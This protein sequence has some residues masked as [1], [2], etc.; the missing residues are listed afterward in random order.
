VTISV[1]RHMTSQF[2]SSPESLRAK[3]DEIDAK[4]KQ[5]QKD[6]ILALHRKKKGAKKKKKKYHI[7]NKVPSPVAEKKAGAETFYC[8]RCGWVCR[9]RNICRS[10][11]WTVL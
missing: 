6:K 1:L 11:E 4:Q 5:E 8:V 3:S 7:A 2:A 10:C 9:G